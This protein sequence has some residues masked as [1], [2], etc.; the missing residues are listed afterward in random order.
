MADINIV[1]WN[2]VPDYDAW[3]FD[4]AWT[5]SQWTNWYTAL[6]EKFG[7]DTA[8]QLWQ[9][10]WDKGNAFKF[11]GGSHLDC[12]MQS[13]FADFAKNNGLQVSSVISSTYLGV[14]GIVGSLGTGAKRTAAV[15]SWLVP[16]ILI[17]LVL[18]A[19]YIL[20]KSVKTG[21]LP[22]GLPSLS[23]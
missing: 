4:D 9:H 8:R 14:E 10:A 5:C 1:Q 12:R 19:S 2:N 11:I 6:V 18:A 13:D 17:M 22:F 20:F 23:A 16:I 15:L 21:K 3:G 7:K